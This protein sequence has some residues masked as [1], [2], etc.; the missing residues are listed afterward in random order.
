[1]KFIQSLLFVFLTSS[2]LW[3]QVPEGFKY[4]SVARNLSGQTINNAPIGL[5]ISILEGSI[6]GTEVY[7]ETHIPTTNNFG[8]F[9]ITIG[10]GTPI[11]SSFPAIDWSLDSKFLK[12]EADF[13]GG[14]SYQLLGTSQFLSVPYSLHSKFAE[15]ANLSDGASAGNT[16][17]WNGTSWIYTNSNI[18]NNGGRVGIGTTNPT[19][20]LHVNGR[21]NVPLD[22]TY[23]INNQTVISTR[24]LSN[25]LLGQSAGLSN[26]LGQFNLFAGFN[27]GILNTI[28]S[29]N[30]F[31]GAETG[32]SNIDGTLNTFIGR[33]AGFSN[34][35]GIENTYVGCYAGQST[36]TGLHNTFLGVTTGNNNS[37]GSENSFYG[38]HAG[39]FNATGNNNTYLGNFAGQYTFSGSDNVYIGFNADGAT[40]NLSNSIAIGSGSVVSAS[41][42]VVVGNAAMTSIGGQVGWSTLSDARLK[43]EVRKEPLGLDFILQLRPVRYS[44][45][46]K[47]Q[48]GIDYSGFIAQDVEQIAKLLNT[49]FSG[50]VAPKN[51]QDFYSVRY[52]EFVVPI[53]N[54]I[55]EQQKMIED[56]K[57]ENKALL[58]EFE[59][60]N[61]ELEK[62]KM[63][64]KRIEA[65]E[66][67]NP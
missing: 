64:E 43:K 30:T 56:L 17:Y 21:I 50:V 45:I 57:I 6:S 32:V 18:H 25:L 23:M 46:A 44:Y 42:T 35:N 67:N 27:A 7:S 16:I 54:S 10:E 53:V 24:G 65:L 12:V 26:N 19:Q 15:S 8:L 36:T 2:L 28:G 59:K 1:M 61:D 9:T 22:S 66:R 40:S 29:Q 58:E 49:S 4:Q 39:Y 20:K 52:A 31:L 48:Q 41:N 62:Y 33:R 60:L 11:T 14:S 55:Q 51:E 5:R 63:L 38:A 37:T 34:T 47:D 3:A 13:T